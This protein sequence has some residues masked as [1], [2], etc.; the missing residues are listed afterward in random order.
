MG[1]IAK[2]VALPVAC[3]VLFAAGCGGSKEE[4]QED[5]F[6]P[7]Q[8]SG[9]EEVKATPKQDIAI[10][11]KDIRFN[12]EDVVLN[13][14][15]T[16]T[17]SNKDRVAHTVTYRSGPRPKFKSGDVAPKK[18]YKRTFDNDPGLLTYL[19]TI[20]ANMTGEIRVVE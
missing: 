18:R 4:K 2:R 12:P 7:A 13:A 8:P 9:G 10:E 19:C 14:G 11:M 16:I 17:W 1:P 3:V 15:G 20:H 6:I 5:A